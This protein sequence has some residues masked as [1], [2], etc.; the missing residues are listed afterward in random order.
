[1]D[2]FY[3][4]IPL[5]LKYIIILHYFRKDSKQ[6]LRTYYKNQSLKAVFDSENISEKE[7]HQPYSLFNPNILKKLISIL[8]PN[9]LS[10]LQNEINKFKN[11]I[12]SFKNSIMPTEIR[13]IKNYVNKFDNL[14][15]ENEE[16]IPENA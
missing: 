4:Y 6:V 11:P 13:T 1:M 15:K 12:N 8:K 16:E 14:F 10:I 5:I 2:N 3:A 9:E 7:I